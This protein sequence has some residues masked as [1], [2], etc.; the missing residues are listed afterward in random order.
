MTPARSAA[1]LTICCRGRPHQDQGSGTPGVLDVSHGGGQAARKPA[2]FSGAH[3]ITLRRRQRGTRRSHRTV[4]RRVVASSSI[5]SRLRVAAAR[6]TDTNIK[7]SFG[8]QIVT[9]AGFVDGYPSVPDSGDHHCFVMRPP[10]LEITSWQTGKSYL[11]AVW[12]DI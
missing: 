6:S 1:S 5:V 10:I 3:P 9:S 2:H 4:A 8:G 11:P 12:S 7:V